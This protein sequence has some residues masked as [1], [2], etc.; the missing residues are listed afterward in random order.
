MHHDAFRDGLKDALAL[1]DLDEATG[2]SE[3]EAMKPDV[4][5]AEVAFVGDTDPGKPGTSAIAAASHWLIWGRRK[6][7]L[8]EGENVV[9]RDPHCEVHLDVPGVSGRHARLWVSGAETTVEDLGSKNGTVKDGRQ[10]KAISSLTDH[11]ELRFGPV[12][13]RYRRWRSLDSTVTGQDLG[14]ESID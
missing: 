8:A 12:A 10:L 13:T 5:R 14:D 2:H 11:D 4:Q 9:G 1:Q 6:F 7:E 3:P